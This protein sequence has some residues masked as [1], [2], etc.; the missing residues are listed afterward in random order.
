VA[1]VACSLD[2]HHQPKTMTERL[3]DCVG[4]NAVLSSSGLVDL[5]CM[6]QITALVPAARQ[7]P[8]AINNPKQDLPAM[9]Y[10]E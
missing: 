6:V 10:K 8:P 1:K 3:D 7:L 2:G 5:A 9:G 4:Y